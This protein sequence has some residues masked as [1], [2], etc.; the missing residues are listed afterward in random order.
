MTHFG[1][2]YSLT[3]PIGHK[4][5]TFT[6]IATCVYVTLVC[7]KFKQRKRIKAQT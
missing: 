3:P 7:K 2:F 1:L 5:L 4:R 6:H